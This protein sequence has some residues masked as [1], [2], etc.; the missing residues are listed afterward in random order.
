ML[1]S[2]AQLMPT[3][4]VLSSPTNTSKG[5]LVFPAVLYVCIYTYVCPIQTNPALST[6][7]I[8]YGAALTPATRI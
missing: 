2:L 6:S 5:T 4:L 7:P 3:I 8:G 1:T